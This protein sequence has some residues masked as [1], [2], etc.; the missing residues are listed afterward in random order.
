LTA[1]LTAKPMDARGHSGQNG[2][3]NPRLSEATTHHGTQ[4]TDYLPIR[5]HQVAGSIPAGGFL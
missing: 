4:W 2:T 5:N 3:R 1:T